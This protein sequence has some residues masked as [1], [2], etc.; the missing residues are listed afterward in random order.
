MC[1]DDDNITWKKSTD[2]SLFSTDFGWTNFCRYCSI[3]SLTVRGESSHEFQ[4]RSPYKIKE[5]K[6]F[7]DDVLKCYLISILYDAFTQVT[8]LFS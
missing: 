3:C 8:H 5:F 6:I 1:R 4:S 2:G 7:T